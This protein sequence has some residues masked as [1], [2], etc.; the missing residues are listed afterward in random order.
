MESLDYP[1]VE[2]HYQYSSFGSWR[3]VVRHRGF[4]LRVVFED[5]EQMLRIERS[6]S[7]DEPSSWETV[8]SEQQLRAGVKDDELANAIAQ[9]A[10]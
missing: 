5:K 3:L 2:H 6:T 8:V 1:I 9:A 7:S 4:P 10:G